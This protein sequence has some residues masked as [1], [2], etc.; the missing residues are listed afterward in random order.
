MS[1]NV[2]LRTMTRIPEENIIVPIS[3][4]NARGGKL[5]TSKTSIHCTELT[6]SGFQIYYLVKNLDNQSFQEVCIL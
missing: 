1:G 6:S 5:L 4:K 3:Q 2:L